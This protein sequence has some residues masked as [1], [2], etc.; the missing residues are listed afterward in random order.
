MNLKLRDLRLAMREQGVEVLLLNH[1]DEY[2]SG[3]VNENRQRVAWLCGFTGSNAF[4]IIRSEGKCIFFTDSRY[5]IQASLEV[6]QSC[7]DIYDMSDVTSAI[8]LKENLP[9]GTIIGYYGELFTLRQIQRFK[10]FCLKM[11]SCQMLDKLWDRPMEIRQRV[12]THPVRFAGLE[13]CDKRAILASKMQSCESMLITDVDSISWLLN[14]R[15]LDFA[16]NPAVLSRAILYKDGRVDLFIEGADRVAIDGKGINVLEI[17]ELP[18]VLKGLSNIAVDAST[19]PIYIFD[20]IKDRVSVIEDQDA[21]T[22]FKAKKNAIEID[23]MKEAHVR[24]GVA[25]VNFLYWLDCSIANNLRV[26]ELDAVSKIREFRQQQDMFMGESFETISGFGGNGAIV[27]YRVDEKSNKVLEKDGIYLIDSGGQY[28]DGTTDIT[29]TVAIGAPSVEQ[30]ARFTMVLKGF[31]AVANAAFPIGTTGAAL[32][33]LARQY[34]WQKQLNY[35][36][37]TGHGVGSF[38]SVHEGPQAISPINSV[39]LEPGM[40]L[41]NEPGYYEQDAYGI[42]IENLMYVVDCGRGFYRFRQLTC[43]PICLDMIDRSMLSREEIEYLNEYHSF[44]FEVI[45]PRVSEE[46]KQWLQ[47]AC[48]R[49]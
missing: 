21:C 22:I 38:L 48:R 26:T 33:V 12:V 34:L 25:V 14:I 20:M 27:H 7:Y 2:Q 15:N 39:P 13:S 18:N 32:D 5:S 11:L 44:V 3:Y 30:V 4:L 28:S 49:I 29:R 47:V 23:G 45:A 35:G 42:R 8:W 40:V 6:D 19:I 43:V 36:H 1:A 9:L 37:S 41:S 24:D 16:Y 17:D 31:I 46:V 10:R